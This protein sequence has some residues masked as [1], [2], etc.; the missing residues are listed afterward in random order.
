MKDIT[1]THPSLNGKTKRFLSSYER[2]IRARDKGDCVEKLVSY[3]S[4][5]EDVIKNKYYDIERLS[6]IGCFI[7]DIQRHT[8]DKAVLRQIIYQ[9]THDSNMIEQIQE[10][11]GDE[12]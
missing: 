11:L 6:G 8:I 1:E 7:E 3:A 4:E 9:N 12:K 10:L 5:S 2:Y